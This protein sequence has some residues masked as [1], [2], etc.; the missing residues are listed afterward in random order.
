MS[1][2]LS[3][4]PAPVQYAFKI[5]APSLWPTVT[6]GAIACGVKDPIVLA[7]LAFHLHHPELSGRSL[8]SSEKGLIAEWK[9]YYRIIKKALTGSPSGLPPAKPAGG[10]STSK[11]VTV[12]GLV[13]AAIADLKKT[14]HLSP[15][16]EEM[17][18][19]LFVKVLRE[20]GMRPGM[21]ATGWPPNKFVEWF[22][23]TRLIYKGLG[24]ILTIYGPSMATLFLTGIVMSAISVVLM[25][26]GFGFA[27]NKAMDT[28]Y[29]CYGC[30][31]QA[32]FLVAWAHG[33][34]VP[35][36]SK[37]ILRL[38]QTPIYGRPPKRELMDSSWRTGQLLARKGVMKAV[39]RIAAES[40]I[41][42]N[43][44]ERVLKMLMRL[45]SKDDLNK[46]MLN[47]IA[48]QTKPRDPQVANAISSQAKSNMWR[49]PH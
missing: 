49:Y 33:D 31:G 17:L 5:T 13:D 46:L 30:Y 1:F 11:G 24:G 28:T 29:R 40:G 45:E 35:T 16:K 41:S 3:K 9:A 26:I 14:E 12:E 21:A 7:D 47:E 27:L 37:E 20:K 38:A 23:Y 43:D 4:F 48:R 22:N 25:I 18:R 32:Y 44:A 2:D 10:G 39:K 36:K 42:F 34:P 15:H 8:K 19:K 6:F